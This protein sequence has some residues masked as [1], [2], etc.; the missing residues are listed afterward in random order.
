MPALV[1]N[2]IRALGRAAIAFSSAKVSSFKSVLAPNRPT[3]PVPL[4]RKQV[5]LVPRQVQSGT[6]TGYNGAAA[7]TIVRCQ[8]VLLTAASFAQI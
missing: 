8:R 1:F 4:Q 2:L 3:T 6:P 5:G 7:I